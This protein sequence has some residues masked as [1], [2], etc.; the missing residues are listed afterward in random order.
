[1]YPRRSGTVW[2][3]DFRQA[4]DE[5]GLSN[6]V[7]SNASRPNGVLFGTRYRQAGSSEPLQGERLNTC[8]YGVLVTRL[9]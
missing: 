7:P 3:A 5:I 8:Y 2:K 6:T 1:M 9:Y 4:W